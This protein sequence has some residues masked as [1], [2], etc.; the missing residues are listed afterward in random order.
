MGTATEALVLTEE[1]IEGYGARLRANGAREGTV[2]TYGGRLRQLR[3]RLADGAVTPEALERVVR[4]LEREGYANQTINVILSAADGLL[5]YAGRRDL[6]YARRLRVRETARVRLTR[7]EY[8]R[9]LGAARLLGKE[10]TY[11]IVKC[12]VL[13][14]L[15]I[16]GLANLT[17][18]AVE[19][20]VAVDGTRTAPIPECL[21]AELL[22]YV[23]EKNLT[24]GAVFL[25]KG[26]SPMSRNHVTGSIKDLAASARVE[27]EKCSVRCLCRLYEDTQREIQD[28]LAT[29]MEQ[30]HRSLL[31]QEQRAIGWRAG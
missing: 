18:E 17:V 27:K 26:G 13:M 19:S 6:Q 5:K 16:Q 28:K 3:E 12:C 25:T 14:G 24:E 30:A 31:E 1:L 9:L 21:R 23:K 8:L 22:D 10:R 11:L 2:A 7:S 4:E 15:G 20:G 29:L